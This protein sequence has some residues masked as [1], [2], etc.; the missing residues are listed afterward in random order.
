[1]HHWGDGFKHFAD[2]S[3]AARDI[4]MFCKRWGRIGVRDY[5]EKYGTARVYCGFGYTQLHSLIWPGHIYSRYPFGVS[6]Y[7]WK[8]NATRFGKW[9]GN[10]IW[11][12]DCNFSRFFFQNKIIGGL[13]CKYQI[14]IYKKAYERALKKY[15]YIVKEI[16]YGADYPELLRHLMPHAMIRDLLGLEEECPF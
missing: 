16:L 15:P 5:K 4:A 1:M 11:R 8:L 14:W 10:K 3:G 13:I 7:G 9:L 6:K 12:L 2:V